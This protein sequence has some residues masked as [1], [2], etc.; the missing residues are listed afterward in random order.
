MDLITKLPKTPRKF[1]AI[2]VI[3]DRLTKSALFLAIRESSTAEQLAEIYVKE[4]VSRHGVPVSIISDR[5][6]RFTS[7]F[8]ER[9]HSE[10]GTRLH[11][12]TAY[13][14]QTDGQSERTIQ[15]LEDMLRACVL[16]FGGSW[17]TY[18][19]LAEFSYNNSYHSSIG[20]PP[21][22]M[23]YER[24][25]RTPICWEDYGGHLEDSGTVADS[26]ES[27]KELCG[28]AEVE[29]GVSGGRS[30]TT[31]GFPMEGCDPVP[32]E[33]QARAS[34]HR[35]VHSPRACREGSLSVGAACGAGSDPQHV[36]RFA[37][38]QVSRRRDGAHSFG[39]YPGGREPELRREAGSGDRSEGEKV[40][41]QGD[42]DREGA[43]AAS[44]G[45]RVDLGAGG[46][47]A[48]ALP[49]A[50][51]RLISGTKSLLDRRWWFTTLKAAVGWMGGS[52]VV[53]VVTVVAVVLP[54][55]RRRR[56]MATAVGGGGW[57]VV[58]GRR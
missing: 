1:D 48:G 47:N 31:Q 10:L 2:W 7:R 33:R 9:F 34:L 46:R 14:P 28:S 39:R 51:L 22:E 32:K 52:V 29:L 56:L 11:F 15:T 17:D 49:G 57:V 55:G 41:E 12:S 21:F 26:S 58:V 4:V 24:R 37:V 42:Q 35:T 3:V 25:C 45:F 53:A 36:S 43:V 8:W 44:E 50:L 38:A 18:L 13:H 23:L 40:E 27:A 30:S 19:P 54:R 16:D 6:V 20:M 5:D